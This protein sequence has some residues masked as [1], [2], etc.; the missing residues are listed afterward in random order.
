MTYTEEMIL[1]NAR[2]RFEEKGVQIQFSARNMQ[3]AIKSYNDSCLRCSMA[4]SCSGHVCSIQK[5][6]LHNTNRFKVELKRNP[7]LRQEV[8]FAL[9]LEPELG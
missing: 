9:E 7:A 6:F 8:K 5:A 3:Q 4:H 2:N 1:D